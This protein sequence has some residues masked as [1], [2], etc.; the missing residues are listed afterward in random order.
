MTALLWFVII[1]VTGFLIGN[2]IAFFMV[3]L[4]SWR[5]YRFVIDTPTSKIRSAAQGYVELTASVSEDNLLLRAPL[6]GEPCCWWSYEIKYEGRKQTSTLEQASSDNLLLIEDDTGSCLVNLHD[7]LVSTNTIDIW[8]GKQRR[9]ESTENQWNA[10]FRYIERRIA[11][12]EV[13]YALGK[14]ASYQ[15]SSLDKSVKQ[16]LMLRNWQQYLTDE[17]NLEN[18][19]LDEAQLASLRQQ[20]AEISET[21]KLPDEQSYQIISVPDDSYLLEAFS[22]KTETDFVGFKRSMV[23]ISLFVG[24][25]SFIAAVLAYR[26]LYAELI[27]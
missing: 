20:L 7:A 13:F 27:A 23:W 12:G 18:Q 10:P 16:E 21:V 24:I 26:F 2:G 5:T 15:A 8:N 19:P 11:V 3:A 1:L 25:G 17:E 9:P 4:H 14:F 22:T 6:S